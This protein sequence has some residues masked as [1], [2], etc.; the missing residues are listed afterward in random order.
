MNRLPLLLIAALVLACLVIAPVNAA[1]PEAE[2]WWKLA[3]NNYSGGKCVGALVFSDRAIAIDPALG[4]AWNVRGCALHCLGRNTAA[5]EA[6]AKA[7]ELDPSLAIAPKNLKHVQADIANGAPLDTP[8]PVI[9]PVQDSAIP[10]D[11]ELAYASPGEPT[12]VAAFLKEGHAVFFRNPGTVAITGI[13]IAGCTYGD[14]RGKKVRVEIRDANLTTLTSDTVPYDGIPFAPVKEE[15]ACLASAGWEEIDLP[16]HP[17]TG[18]FY[19][20]LF[21]GSGLI[22]Q[23]EPGLFI[24]FTTP[25]DAKTSSVAAA[26]QNRLIPQEISAR[27]DPVELDWM[28]SVLYMEPAGIANATGEPA[29]LPQAPATAGE[30]VENP[31][32]AANRSGETMV[33]DIPAPV[34]GGTTAGPQETTTPSAPPGPLVIAVSLA[35]VALRSWSGR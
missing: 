8:V 24:V 20:V 3:R 19:L 5:L 10:H 30:N 27:Y 13:R 7:T 6:F 25:S 1:S 26:G 29:A 11:G 15:A 16:D 32:Q 17:V 14:T 22:S 21:T 34:H 35:I 23:K 9:T 33:Q 18:D 28:V 31:G 2:A 4:R 12:G